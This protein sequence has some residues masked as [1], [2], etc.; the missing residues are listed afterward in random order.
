MIFRVVFWMGGAL[1]SFSTMA[2]SVRQLAW[3]GLSIFEILAIRSGGSLLILL[4]LLAVRP[5]LRVHTL[6]ALCS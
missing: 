3:A 4:A 5:E 2:V 6:S 1:L